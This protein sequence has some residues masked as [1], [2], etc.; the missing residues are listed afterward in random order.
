MSWTS[1]SAAFLCAIINS[2]ELHYIPDSKAD[3]V[4]STQ[5]Q[6]SLVGRPQETATPTP[7]NPTPTPHPVSHVFNWVLFTVAVISNIHL[8]T[9][10]SQT[11]K[12][13]QKVKVPFSQSGVNVNDT[14]AIAATETH[15][16][17]LPFAMMNKQSQP[18]LR[19]YILSVWA[20]DEQQLGLH[21][22]NRRHLKRFGQSI[23][24]SA[25]MTR[26]HPGT[27]MTFQGQGAVLSP[28]PEKRLHLMILL[29]SAWRRFFS[30]EC[31]SESL[32]G[33]F[34]KAYRSSSCNLK[35]LPKYL[36]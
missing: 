24:A 15:D 18:S 4:A 1:L 28:T 21:F 30:V 16:H 35:R 17:L 32:F 34:T 2:V 27:L 11:K 29:H 7:L 33:V 25:Q 13:R 31:I 12:A 6:E 20:S 14:F 22:I 23:L 19:S 26:V 8:M 10:A 5:L 9:A 3:M 36:D